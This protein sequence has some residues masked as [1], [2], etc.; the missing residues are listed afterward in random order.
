MDVNKTI[1]I[2]EA[3]ASGCSPKTGE[4]IEN[5]SV[6]NERD[7][8]RAL[9]LAI[10][11]L[12]KQKQTSSSEV[13]IDEEEIKAAI[14]LFREHKHAPT[15]NGLLGF[16][17]G[18]RKFKTEAFLTN[19]L[20]GK[21]KDRYRKGQLLDFFT[22]YLEEYKRTNRSIPVNNP[23]S[24][25]DFFKKERFN[26]L[27][28]SAIIQLKEKVNELGVQKTENISAYVLKARINYPRAYE[29]WTEKE[30]KLL[31][32]AIEYTND[33]DLLSECFQRGRGSIESCGQILI[34]ESKNL[35]DDRKEN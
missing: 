3:L 25:I 15:S 18:I 28:E 34:Y 4:M 22:Q 30:K 29:I 21:Y 35:Q 1:E 12:K 7:V 9:Q 20:Y 27:Y 11:K 31:A 5:E 16:F 32:K 33:L 23:Y 10:D 19:A 6:L 24:E 13:E 17:L 14:Q 2:L 8:I 26:K